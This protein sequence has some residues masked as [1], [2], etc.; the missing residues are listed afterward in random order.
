M[1]QHEAQA[2]E[3]LA[4]LIGLCQRAGKCASGEEACQKA[5]RSGKARLMLLCASAGPNTEKRFTNMAAQC[6]VPIWRLDKGVLESATGRTNLKTFVVTDAGFGRE[7]T[8]WLAYRTSGVQA[9]N[10]ESQDQ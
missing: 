9:V 4:G 1:E 5:L 8:K 2:M 10:V 7:M 3:R 6:K